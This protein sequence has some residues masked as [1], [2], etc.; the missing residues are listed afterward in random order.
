MDDLTLTEAIIAYELKWRYRDVDEADLCKCL[1]S[2]DVTTF[3][4]LALPFHCTAPKETF[5]I[6]LGQASS[7]CLLWPPIIRLGKLF[8]LLLKLMQSILLLFIN[9]FP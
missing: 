7:Q 2:S 9:V 8:K 6:A 1:V 3:A 5:S 4:I